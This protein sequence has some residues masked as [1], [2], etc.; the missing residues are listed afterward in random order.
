MLDKVIGEFI[1]FIDF[2]DFDLNF[3]VFEKVDEIVFYVLVFFVCGMC[4]E[5]KFVLVYFL[6]SEVIVV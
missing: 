2:G 5:L 6:I 1:G 4:I 3:V